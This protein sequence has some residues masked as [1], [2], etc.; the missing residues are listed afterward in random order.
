MPL[1]PERHALHR[2]PP[3]AA[4]RTRLPQVRQTGHQL[5]QQH[6]GRQHVISIEL[7]Q[8]MSSSQ[9][10]QQLMIK[11]KARHTELFCLSTLVGLNLEEMT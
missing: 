3:S 6:Y 5:A 4:R 9:A 7:Q 1:N 8:I 10:K 11:R 2:A